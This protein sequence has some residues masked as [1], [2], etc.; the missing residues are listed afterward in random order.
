M[1]LRPVDPAAEHG[2]R[3]HRV[4][5]FARSRAGIWYARHIASRVDPWLH[6]FTRG[7]LNRPW[8]IPSA[9]LETIGAR[10]GSVRVVQ[11]CYFHDSSGVV[12]VASNFGDSAHPGWYHNLLAHPQCRLGGERFIASEVSDPDEYERLFSLAVRLYAGWRDYR[13]RTDAFGR[14]IPVLRLTPAA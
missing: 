13:I 11:I 6:R 4:E 1:P 14:H 9:P 10:T 5:R 12:V 8:T 3:Y 2:R 7:W